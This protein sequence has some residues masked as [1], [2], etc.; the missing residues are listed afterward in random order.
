MSKPYHENQY[1]VE[2]T[3]ITKTLKTFRSETKDTY[4]LNHYGP[5][6]SP[7]LCH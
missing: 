1:A 7:D 4:S 3:Y 5:A 6:G 2:S